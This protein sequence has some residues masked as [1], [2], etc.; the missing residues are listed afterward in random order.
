MV[1]WR[2][3]GY[4]ALMLPRTVPTLWTI[5]RFSFF[6]QYARFCI[7]IPVLEQHWNGGLADFQD[8]S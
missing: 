1:V 6:T 2:V 4:V 5:S 8:E 7:K 3:D